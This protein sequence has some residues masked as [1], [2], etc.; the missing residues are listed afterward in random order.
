MSQ[1][2]RVWLWRLAALICLI[3]GV[4]FLTSYTYYTSVGFDFGWG[5]PFDGLLTETYVRARFPG[6]GSFW[7]GWGQNQVE[8][9]TGLIDLAATFFQPPKEPPASF[10]Q[11]LGFWN[12]GVRIRPNFHYHFLGVPS[13]LPL[14]IMIAPLTAY[15]IKEMKNGEY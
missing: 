5:A 12:L 3:Y 13:W 6:N 1:S 8:A 2:R 10:W 4:L 14:I 7:L 11:R 9:Q 15:R